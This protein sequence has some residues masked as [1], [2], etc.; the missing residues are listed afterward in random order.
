MSLSETTIT[1]GRVAGL[2]GLVAASLWWD[3]GQRLVRHRNHCGRRIT[4]TGKT[5]LRRERKSLGAGKGGKGKKG[6]VREG[7]QR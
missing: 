5:L 6:L 4:E 7:L 1:V 2:P 3:R